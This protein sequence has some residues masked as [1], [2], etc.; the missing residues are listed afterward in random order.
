MQDYFIGQHHIHIMITIEMRL[1][2]IAH[3]A[4]DADRKMIIACG[5]RLKV[6]LLGLP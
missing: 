6:Q 5:R 1:V 4:I 3:G 2:V